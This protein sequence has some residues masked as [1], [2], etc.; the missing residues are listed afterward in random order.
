MSI[1]LIADSEFCNRHAAANRPRHLAGIMVQDA[2]VDFYR[3][4]ACK[5]GVPHMNFIK[6]LNTLYA[7]HGN[8]EGCSKIDLMR[9]VEENPYDSDFWDIFRPN[10]D[11]IT[12]P[13]YLITSLA[14][15][16]VHT[17]GSIRGYLAA[18]STTKYI[19]LHP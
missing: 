18:Q 5:G 3:E 13:L 12:C 6:V 15:N 10:T 14:D 1:I 2:Y 17:P 19:E 7:A 11:Q 8:V 9:A 16:G 4:V